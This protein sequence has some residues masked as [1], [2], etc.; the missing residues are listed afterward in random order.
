MSPVIRR[1]PASLAWLW[2]LD[3]RLARR[4]GRV[5]SAIHVAGTLYAPESLHN[6]RIALEKV[7]QHVQLAHGAKLCRDRSEPSTEL[8]GRPAIQ[9]EERDHFAK[10]P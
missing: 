1:R 9:P 3:A 7:E 6:V 2:A 8:P 4:A 10:S 5:R